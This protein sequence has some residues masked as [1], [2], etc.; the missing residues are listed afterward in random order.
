[1]LFSHALDWIAWAGLALP[2]AALAWSALQYV[3]GRK[4][5]REHETF[6]RFFALVKRLGDHEKYGFE[7]GAILFE[8]RNFNSQRDYVIR[9]LRHFPI[10]GPDTAFLTKEVEQTLKFLETN[11]R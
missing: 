8:L 6:L 1:M 7:T 3:S 5:E 9:M 11:K 4:R 2:L 10:T